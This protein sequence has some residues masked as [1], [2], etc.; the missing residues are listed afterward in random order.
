L[1]S[2]RLGFTLGKGDGNSRESLVLIELAILVV[3]VAVVIWALNP[4]SPPKK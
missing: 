4:P 3:L 2:T 1:E